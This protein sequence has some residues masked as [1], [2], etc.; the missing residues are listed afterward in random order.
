MIQGEMI[1]IFFQVTPLYVYIG[2]NEIDIVPC[3]AQA[4][5]AVQGSNCY[6]NYL[7]DAAASILKQYLSLLPVYMQHVY[8]PSAPKSLS[9][10]RIQ[11]LSQ[12]T[13]HFT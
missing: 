12:K 4:V 13:C 6:V 10:Y 3:T 2:R 9:F 1:N 8:T 11:N 7:E 5:Y